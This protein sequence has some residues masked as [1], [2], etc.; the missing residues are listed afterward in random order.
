MKG[1]LVG[2]EEGGRY[3]RFIV[4]GKKQG[5]DEE[6]SPTA[7]Q[8]WDMFC[9]K[10]LPACSH[11]TVRDMVVH[12]M[13]MHTVLRTRPGLDARGWCRPLY[14]RQQTILILMRERRQIKAKRGARMSARR[15]TG[16]YEDIAKST[17]KQELRTHTHTYS[18]VPTVSTKGLRTDVTVRHGLLMGAYADPKGDSHAGS[19]RRRQMAV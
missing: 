13:N 15:G 3:A 1:K 2:G 9:A 12:S 8:G 19:R 4:E 16:L 6:T 10:G 17:A 11:L 14:V 18:I 5:D 7:Q